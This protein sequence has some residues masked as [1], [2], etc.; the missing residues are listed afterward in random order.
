MNSLMYVLGPAGTNGHAA[1]LVSGNSRGLGSENIAF[2]SNHLE[3]FALTERQGGYGVVAIENSLGGLVSEVMQYWVN[4][5]DE[6]VLYIVGEVHLP[7]AHHLLVDPRITELSDIRSVTSHEQALRQCQVNLSQLGLHVGSA[8]S[9]TA[10]A[11]MEIGKTVHL[12]FAS[13]T[14]ALAS[15]LAARIYGLKILREHMEDVKTNSTRFH[16]VGKM[17]TELTGRD[18]TAALFWIPNRPR[19]LADILSAIGTQDVNISSM[20]AI[21]LGTMGSFAHYVEFDCH[22]YDER[23]AKII[24]IMKILTDRMIILGSFPKSNELVMEV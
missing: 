19:A 24:P 1:G 3:V 23:G 9:S 14:A 2:C 17:P 15:R 7:I 5:K 18:R 16:V 8:Y 21:P 22:R 20:H 12:P 6:S 4:Q 10:H 13:G 11:A